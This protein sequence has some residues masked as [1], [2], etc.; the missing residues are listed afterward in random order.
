MYGREQVLRPERNY[1]IDNNSRA[2]DP[3]VSLLC[4]F[5]EA[6]LDKFTYLRLVIRI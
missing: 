4:E 6:K 1:I 2:S 3:A 5:V